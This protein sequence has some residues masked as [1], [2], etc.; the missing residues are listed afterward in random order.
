MAGRSVKKKNSTAPLK[1]A[2]TLIAV[3]VVLLFTVLDLTG[4]VSFDSLLIKAGVEDKPA[5]HAQ[6]EVH[7]IDVGQGDSTLVISQGEA[8]LIDSGDKDDSNKIEKYLEKQGVTELKYLIATHP[9]A[10]HIGEMSE[11]IDQFQVD[12]FI[13]PKVKA[14]MT[15]TTTIYEKMLKSIKAK[16]LKITQAKPM[17]FELGSCKVEL[18]TPKNDYDNLNNYSTLVKITDGENSFLI[19]GDCETAE[20]KDILSQGYDVSAKVLK[21]GHHG[22]STSSGVDFLNKVMPRY[23]VISCGKGNKY[24]HPHEETVTRLKKYASHLYVTADVGTIV[25]SS[26]GEG[27][28]VSAEKGEK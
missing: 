14:D 1:K 19:T 28:S 27:L 4:L 25:F 9:H 10:D 24:G 22:S 16:G 5:E 11:I 23:A 2:V 13:M 6:T 18:F 26:D 12:K 7:F 17:E 21:A 20:E 15:P 8:M 3:F